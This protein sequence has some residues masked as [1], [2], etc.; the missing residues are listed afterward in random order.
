MSQ[1]AT[2]DLRTV[3]ATAEGFDV[4]RLA[5]THRAGHTEDWR[6]GLEGISRRP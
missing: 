4:A 1:Q 6:P 3:P 5:G 2:T